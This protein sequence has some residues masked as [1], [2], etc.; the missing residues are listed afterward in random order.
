MGEEEP[1]RRSES[2]G[3]RHVTWRFSRSWYLMEAQVVLDGVG[4]EED[5]SLG[6]HHQDE[7]VQG[8]W[9]ENT[10]WVWEMEFCVT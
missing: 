3:W 10:R 4:A 7:A 5:D 6:R 8:L 2:R 1:L 9:T